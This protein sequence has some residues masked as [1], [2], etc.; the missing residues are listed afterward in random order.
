ME[1]LLSTHTQLHLWMQIKDENMGS[2]S[3][4][5]QHIFKHL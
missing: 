3:M 1:V 5:K 4:Q 2:K